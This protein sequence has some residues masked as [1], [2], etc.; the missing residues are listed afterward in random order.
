MS[1]SAPPTIS[2]PL[3][4]LYLSPPETENSQLLEG[5]AFITISLYLDLFFC[6]LILCLR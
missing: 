6:W 1:L 2:N 5:K 4:I 3:R